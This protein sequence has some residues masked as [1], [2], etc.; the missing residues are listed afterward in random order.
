MNNF[1]SFSM[2]KLLALGL[3]T[4]LSWS[5]AAKAQECESLTIP[6]SSDGATNMSII[7]CDRDGIIDRVELTYGGQDLVIKQDPA[8]STR[9]Y[10]STIRRDPGEP[11]FVFC[12]YQQRGKRLRK[13]DDIMR[14]YDFQKI[15]DSVHP[16]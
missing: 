15:W 5:V 13:T 3:A 4:I 6:D 2:R 16:R 14:V 8:N 10:G 7:D 12:V 9:W 11:Y 1:L